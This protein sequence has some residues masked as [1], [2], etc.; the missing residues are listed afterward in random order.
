MSVLRRS[1]IALCVLAL[2]ACGGEAEPPRAAKPQPRPAAAARPAPGAD[3]RAPDPAAEAP[4]PQ[5]AVAE[6]PPEADYPQ[7]CGD[8]IDM[9]V[10]FK[11]SQKDRGK[12]VEVPDIEQLR[13]KYRRQAAKQDADSLAQMCAVGINMVFSWMEK[14]SQQPD[15]PPPQPTPEP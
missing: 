4:A 13:L 7:A 9:L 3:A 12:K 10:N 14:E 15:L 8:Y 5:P 11:Q 6:D 1:A 2:V